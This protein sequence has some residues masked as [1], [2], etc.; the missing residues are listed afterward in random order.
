MIDTKLALEIILHCKAN[1]REWERHYV[2]TRARKYI[3]LEVK[4]K[5]VEIL[6]KCKR[7][8]LHF[9]MK[10]SD[11]VVLLTTNKKRLAVLLM[12]IKDWLD[13]LKTSRT[14]SKLLQSRTESWKT[15]MKQQ[16]IK[17]SL[18]PQLQ[19][20]HHRIFNY[21][22]KVQAKMSAILKVIMKVAFNLK[23]E[24]VKLNGLIK[25]DNFNRN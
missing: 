24:E 11:W 22:I 5:V 9:S 3:R 13:Y 1:C 19:L 21:Q 8:C 20:L 7:S 16:N 4:I 25:F 6:N 12:I 14:T 17:T 23:W 2:H 15:S 18:Q 10:T